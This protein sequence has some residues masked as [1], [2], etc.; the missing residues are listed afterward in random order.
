VWDEVWFMRLSLILICGALA[1]LVIDAQGLDLLARYPTP[2]TVGDAAPE[3]ARVWEFAQ[4]DIFLLTRFDLKVSQDLAVQVGPADLGIGHCAD[5]AVWAVI[6]PRANGTLKH[7]GAHQ[8]AVGHVWL[9]FHPREIN[10]LFPPGTVSPDNATNLVGQIRIIAKAKMTASWQAGG[11]A[12]IPEP[13]DLT[14]DVDTQGGPRRF[15]VV[16][17][18]A[19]TARY[20]A[21]FEQRTVKPSPA[22]TPELAAEAFDQLWEAFDSEYA[23]FALRPELDW[24]R[25]REQSRDGALAAKTADEF[26]D[27]CG[28]ILR[29]LRDLHVWLNVAGAPVPVFNRPR[30]ANSNPSAHRALL[31]DLHVQGHVQWAVTPDKIG[32]LAIYGWDTGP[33]I[34]GLCDEA[35]EAM[36]NTRALVVDV[37]LNGG[38]DEPTARNVAGRFLSKEFVYAYSQFRNGPSH[39]DLTEKYP[40]K[41][42][43][44]GP[45][46]YD[47]P[48]LLLIGQKCM[49]SNESFIGMMT[50]STN[51]TTMGDHTCGSSGNPKIIQLPLDITVSV[52]RWI[53]YLPDGTPL[54]ERGFQPQVRFVSA[55]GAFQAERDDL[56]AAALERLRQAP[57]SEL[58]LKPQA[59]SRSF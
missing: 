57:P 59:P 47:R 11:Q 30:T 32:F 52:P 8:E 53:D 42:T 48:V 23:M 12:M 49:S 17:R 38:G 36:R 41:V 56:L 3:R 20:I 10:R 6:L 9:R 31:G 50:G 14:V 33:E 34:P 25:L 26:A 7:H 54:D 5:G 28:A 44:R 27:T 4:R 40:R 46:R 24:A 22:I 35:L 15:F 58:P 19:E 21:A 55:P 37:R 2:L 43:P 51:V 29:P 1:A 39:A 45:W 16:D 18:E 13:K